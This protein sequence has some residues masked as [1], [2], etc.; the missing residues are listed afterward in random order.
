MKNKM[1]SV[2]GFICILMLVGLL[3]AGVC[4]GRKQ[5]QDLI[6]IT[7][8]GYGF[9]SVNAREINKMCNE[10]FAITYEIKRKATAET[11]NSEYPV[12]LIG[13]NVSYSRILGLKELS[14]S[15]FT[16]EA[17]NTGSR[18]AVLNENAAF[19]LFGGGSIIGNSVTLDG[20]SYRIT[21][22]V[23]DEY[24]KAAMVY[25]PSSTMTGAPEVLMA[26]T[27]GG[28]GEVR[29]S[30]TKLN[31]YESNSR[32]IDLSALGESFGQFLIIAIF[33]SLSLVSLFVAY[34]GLIK[35]KEY[36]SVLKL[37]SQL[38]YMDQL[39]NEGRRELKG[40][41]SQTGIIAGSFIIFCFLSQ[42]ILKRILEWKDILE[43]FKYLSDSYFLEKVQWLIRF[44]Y[45]GPVLFFIF[46]FV[47]FVIVMLIF[48]KRK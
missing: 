2:L 28:K 38:M 1:I 11:V 33:L 21:G 23:K 10:D 24:N 37:R 43:D 40:L 34:R 4:A 48:S 45:C 26:K 19:R 9:P 27:A 30:L 39:M 5:Y 14:G 18:Y 31:V 16:E 6:L 12:T 15:F 17:W 25:V 8:Y 36:Y 35:L 22:I 32:L 20:E 13:T 46:V 41:V 7:P 29:T 47:L 44:F 42:E 3:F